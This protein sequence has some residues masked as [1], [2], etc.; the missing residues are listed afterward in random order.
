MNIII[1][2]P[3]TQH[4][5]FDLRNTISEESE[6]L[7]PVTNAISKNQMS[8]EDYFGKNPEINKLT[9]IYSKIKSEIASYVGKKI[10]ANAS[11]EINELLSQ[12][13]LILERLF[14]VESCTTQIVDGIGIS[15]IPIG[16]GKLD[17]SKYSKLDDMSA[18]KEFNATEANSN[19]VKYKYSDGKH[20]VL[21]VGITLFAN[22]EIKPEF[23]T[24][25]I[26]HEC[27]KSFLN[28]S[29]GYSIQFQRCVSAMT[30]TF[31]IVNYILNVKSQFQSLVEKGKQIKAASVDDIELIKTVYKQTDGE[32]L[33]SIDE[34]ELSRKM[35]A[36]GKRLGNFA[37][38]AKILVSSI[39]DFIKWIPH[40]YE[41]NWKDFKSVSDDIRHKRR[42]E[43][44]R[45]VVKSESDSEKATYY[46]SS[47][48][49]SMFT[50]LTT[51]LA[52][53]SFVQKLRYLNPIDMNSISGFVKDSG[54]LK[55]VSS[56]GLAAEY[57]E[58]IL[59]YE[60]LIKSK[61]YEKRGF[62]RP[63]R[64]IPI[65][66]VLTQLP[67]LTVSTFEN[68]SS[69][70]FSTRAKIRKVYKTLQKE[71]ETPGLNPKLKKSIVK[72]MQMIETVYNEYIDPKKNNASGNSARAF[73][74]F[75]LR[76]LFKLDKRK[77]N[78]DGLTSAIVG[79]DTWKASPDIPKM[80][81]MKRDEEIASEEI[82]ESLISN[83]ELSTE[84]SNGLDSEIN[85][86]QRFE[87]SF[88]S[89]LGS[90]NLE[91]YFGKT[92]IVN[93]SIS[94]IHSIREELKNVKGK[95]TPSQK[96]SIKKILRDWSNELATEFNV[97]SAYVG[98]EDVYNAY[99]YPMCIGSSKEIKS[100]KNNQII[101]SSTGYKFSN[102]KGVS[103]IVC[104]G[105]QLLCDFKLTDEVICAVIFHEIGHGFQQYEGLAVN[106][107]KTF[108]IYGAFC[109]TIK[110]FV[111]DICNLRIMNVISFPINLIV[112]I[113]TGF[114]LGVSRNSYEK[115]LDKSTN[116]TIDEL[117]SNDT[118]NTKAVAYKSCGLIKTVQ[119]L[120]MTAFTYLPL[121]GISSLAM[122]IVNDPLC[123]VDV[124]FR[125][126]YYSRK[127]K[128]ENFAD[129]FATK[130]GLGIDLSNFMN[131]LYENQFADVTKIPLLKTIEEFNLAGTISMM[132]VLEDHPTYRLR[133]K[134]MY[135][136]IQKELI[137]NK[138]LPQNLRES[139]KAEL[140]EIEK[141]YSEMIDPSV[142]AKN[143]RFGIGLYMWVL[144]TF[145]QLKK[146]SKTPEEFAS[147]VNLTKSNVVNSAFKTFKN[148][149]TIGEYTGISD[150]ELIAAILDEEMLSSQGVF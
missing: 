101:E 33:D 13:D 104:V 46:L 120:L 149:P 140:S 32:K 125:G 100:A 47:Q 83:P 141:L 38:Y 89:N 110:S 4:L 91:S 117:T 127:K 106:K 93:S 135:D 114:G 25:L 52:S 138:D 108:E 21:S 94:Y 87:D 126:R 77:S 65:F 85:W 41:M 24:A 90:I 48:M 56:Y 131:R 50:M 84:S 6:F 20:L 99:A 137:D 109:E 121:P 1:Q 76:F 54:G 42:D 145:I 58:A 64:K 35:S 27:G 29:F 128:N 36:I 22:S 40:M 134:N 60:K 103:I 124:V 10:D 133:I 8:F 5:F 92:E 111:Y 132:S 79:L 113:F 67:W 16:A 43:M 59:V 70:D 122:T 71:L 143:K 44:M 2:S 142:N 15:S 53:W 102:A 119:A 23:L 73:I 147:N 97:E 49:S 130:Y 129:S 68:I 61:E 3:N 69:G 12:S 78:K 95:I 144:K 139:M 86:K 18:I 80:V 14:N 30:E 57:S 55:F 19:G 96:D 63:F 37:Y 123:L 9:K 112:G 39:V 26:F 146:D 45:L 75:A 72:Q 31:D 66:N 105:L 118:A 34:S 51:L 116:K 136:T 107:A 98:V 81:D 62:A 17:L 150:K 88:Y 28:Y 11:V 7:S 74:Y 148:N 82:L 115:D